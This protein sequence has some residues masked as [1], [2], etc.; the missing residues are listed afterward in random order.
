MLSLNHEIDSFNSINDV[1]EIQSVA[2][3]K[4]K[5][6]TRDVTSL[7]VR[8]MNNKMKQYG[9]FYHLIKS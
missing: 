5:D 2:S 1:S 3:Q 7:K 8:N 6:L 9:L 4:R